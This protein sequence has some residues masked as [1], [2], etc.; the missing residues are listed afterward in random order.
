[1]DV[2]WLNFKGKHIHTMLGCDGRNA[3]LYVGPDGSREDPTAILGDPD[4]MV[5]EIVDSGSRLASSHNTILAQMFWEGKVPR[6]KG[7]TAPSR[8]IEPQEGARNSSPRLKAESPL[9]RLSIGPDY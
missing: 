3:F 1:V 2:V 8:C 4:D 5:I 6:E 7:R 9:S